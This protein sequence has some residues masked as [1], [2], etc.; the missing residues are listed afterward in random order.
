MKISKL[1][2]L[3][4]LVTGVSM[5]LQFATSST[6]FA[7]NPADFNPGRIIDDE[8]FYNKNA[9]GSAAEVQQFITA[10]TPA[11]DTWGTQPSGYGSLNRAQYAQQIMGW[12]GPPYVCLQNY[13]ENP[14]TGETSFEK[15]GGAFAGGVSAAEIIYSASQQYN[16]NPQVL[17]VMLRKESLNLFSDDWPLKSQ[18]KY[19]MGYA[20]PDAGPNYS[21]AC[22][23]SKAGFYKQVTL[24]AWQLR[25]YYDHM[26]EYNFAPAR[27]N[28][29]QYNPDP[30]CG[31]KDVYIQNYATASLY[32]YTPYTPN[33]AA[34]YAYPGTANCGAYGNRNFWFMWQEWFGSPYA[35]ANV[36]SSLTLLSSVP[37]GGLYTN[38]FVEASFV[39]K[40][41]S[42]YVN[43]IGYIA[44]ACRDS[45]GANCDFPS[46]RVILQPGQEYLYRTAVNITKEDKYSFWIT[47]YRNGVWDDMSPASVNGAVRRYD[48]KLVQHKPTLTVDIASEPDL[49]INKTSNVTFSARNNSAYPLNMGN[50]AVGMRSP[51]GKNAD[52]VPEAVSNLAPG[53]TYVYT[54]PFTPKEV[55]V[56]SAA[57]L[58]TFNFSQWNLATFPVP[59]NG[60]TGRMSFSV[61]SNPT[62]TQGLSISP[63]NPRAG[64]TVTGTFKVKNFGTQPVVVNKKLCFVAGGPGGVNSDFGCLDIGTIQPSQEL[65]FTGARVVP[66]GG[67]YNGLFA[68]Y[69]GRYWYNNWSFEQETGTEPKTVS[70]SVAP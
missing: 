10:H 53:A 37:G 1:I 64:D 12:A 30:G 17:L 28:T 14:T 7:V 21:A 41:N 20:C 51:S 23:D 15:G 35:N 63:S 11:C 61:K 27:W 19:A 45:A 2:L 44:V 55:G 40:N 60:T 47:N 26:G 57:L 62:I 52:L 59:I 70:F 8:V 66:V 49:R 58:S 42:S 68:M 67:Q 9:M 65:T 6:A 33:D 50:V 29:I 54:K 38:G 5:F 32:I 34:L 56:Y 3:L 46:Q 16:I 24:A 4:G 69:D 48:N 22:V 36:V 13:Y 39:I 18:Y 31:T 25:Y 43:D